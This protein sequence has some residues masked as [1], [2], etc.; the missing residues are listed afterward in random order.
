M[1][2]GNDKILVDYDEWAQ[3]SGREH[4][5]GLLSDFLLTLVVSWQRY[6]P[7]AIGPHSDGEI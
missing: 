3:I 7:Q 4:G 2:A 1:S 6:P 5:T